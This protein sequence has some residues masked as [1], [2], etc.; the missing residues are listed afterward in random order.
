M[1]GGYK[2]YGCDRIYNSCGHHI[3]SGGGIY[4]LYSASAD[5]R[6][7]GCYKTD[8]KI[9]GDLMPALVLLVAPGDCRR[10]LQQ[11]LARWGLGVER[12][13]CRVERELEHR[14]C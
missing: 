9:L 6:D 1:S 14:G 2:K 11:R 4:F 7:C 8:I 3:I 13:Q 12:E 5:N 10:Q